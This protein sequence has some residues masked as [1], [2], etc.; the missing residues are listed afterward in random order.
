MPNTL[1]TPSVVPSITPDAVSSSSPVGERQVKNENDVLCG[2]GGLSNKNSG[3]RVFRRLVNFNKQNYQTCHDPSHKH[4]L[5]VSVIM[6][7]QRRGGRFLRKQGQVW[8]EISHNDACVK[9]AQ[10]LREQDAVDSSTLCS[11][12]SSIKTKCTASSEKEKSKKKKRKPNRVSFS[13]SDIQ[14]FS[15]ATSS[16]ITLATPPLLQKPIVPSIIQCR[17]PLPINQSSLYTSQHPANEVSVQDRDDLGPTV[18]IC[19]DIDLF[20]LLLETLSSDDAFSCGDCDMTASHT[21]ATNVR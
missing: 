3:N 14:E 8:V 2:R 17:N 13:D 1:K 4:L 21:D 10:A 11:V 16:T 5:V 6:A 9:T 19:D 12:P 20:Q 7:T 18:K 15:Q